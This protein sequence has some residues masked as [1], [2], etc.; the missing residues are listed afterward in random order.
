MVGN[1]VVKVT[2]QIIPKYENKSHCCRRIGYYSPEV[3]LVYI[4]N[5]D[6]KRNIFRNNQ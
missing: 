6:H 2:S 3:C 1:R 4:D 5:T